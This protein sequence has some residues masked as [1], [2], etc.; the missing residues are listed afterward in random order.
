MSECFVGEIRMLP[1]TFTP[2]NWTPC[3]GQ[4]FPI[5]QFQ[6]LYAVI[7]NIY[8]GNGV[9]NFAVPDMKDRAPMHSGQGPGLSFQPLATTPG[10]KEVYLTVGN[11]PD[12]T[13]MVAGY[14]D[15]ADSHDP[16]GQA[17]G[18]G[19]NP[20]RGSATEIYASP[21][22]LVGMA[23]EAVSYSGQS[24]PHPNRQPYVAIPFCMALDGSFPARN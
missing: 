13:H 19:K 2:V 3:D 12:H 6:M 5:S 10:E 18:L 14:D 24:Q 8:G 1:Y 17:L 23:N 7:G 20:R 11:L 4:L 22:N 15:A 9:H 21:T 16:T